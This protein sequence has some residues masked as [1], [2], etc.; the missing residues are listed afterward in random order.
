PTYSNLVHMPVVPGA[1]QAVVVSVD[2]ADPDGLGPLTLK[3]AVNGGAWQNVAM[4]S[5]NA[6]H[7]SATIPAQVAAAVVQFYVQ[8]VD[9]VGATSFAP[10]AGTN[11]RA[12]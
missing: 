4:S 10:A 7:F 5:S 3:Y 1:A 8:G 6:K 2:A 11:S 12:M 9:G